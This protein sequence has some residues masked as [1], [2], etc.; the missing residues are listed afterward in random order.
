MDEYYTVEEMENL[1]V[2]KIGENVRVSKKVSIYTNNEIVLGNNVRIDD[3]CILVGHIVIHNFIHLG[4]FCGLHASQ[5]GRIIFEDFSGISSNVNIYA[6]SDSFDGEYC[7]ARLG[8]PDECTKTV[9]SEVRLGKY[10]QIGTGST[11]LPGGSLG[12]GTAVG[13]M[14]LVNKKLEPWSI[15]AGVPCHRLR[16]RSRNMKK[17]L[18]SFNSR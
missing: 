12:E 14:S 3:Y 9:Y 2:K 6:S 1:G 11:V 17:R 18:I 10:S 7:T 15:Y 5:G 16:E 8:L 4:A 13:A